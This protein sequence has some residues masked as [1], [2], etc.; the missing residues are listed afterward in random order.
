MKHPRP[1]R[2]HP[3]MMD[4]FERYHRQTLLP[5]IGREGQQRLRESSVLVVG[6]GALGTVIA[7]S[8]A[9]AGAGRL[10][11]VDR[12]VVERTNLQ[13][14]VLFDEKDAA[15]GTPKAVAARDRLHQIN[16]GVSIEPVVADFNPINAER[17]AAGCELILDGTD[18]FETRF[19]LND[20]A[21]KL[22]LPYVYGGAVGTRGM[23]YTVL[24][25]TA[26]D[27]SPWERNGNGG[28]GGGGPCLRC[29][30]DGAPPA[31]GETCDTVGVL[32]P[33]VGLVANHQAAEAMK[34]LTGNLEHVSRDLL[35]ID[36]WRNEYRHV[37][38]AGAYEQ[39]R[40]VCCGRRCFEYLEGER[41]TRTATLCGRN[42]VQVSAASGAN[43]YELDLGPIA[44]RLRTQA[45]IT[46]NE[47]L[48]RAE[49]NEN[50][51][52]YRLTL[53]PDGRAIVHGTD[54]PAVAKGLY[55]RY[56]GL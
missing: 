9:R 40:C 4:D 15:R 43:G 46:R 56:V 30:F 33:A 11:I 54:D 22:G 7:E 32:G 27:D 29:I 31:G 8:L 6:C 45:R 36:P 47:F 3:Y 17:I 42:A 49:L 51:R 55:A 16:S 37:S 28:G 23:S 24:P 13:R 39:G 35:T 53:F 34:L 20:L 52:D 26:G 48:L 5:G 2:I 18:N 38:V 14:Q 1:E 12:D 50:D 25:H 19:L 44:D 21:V 41:S 10:V